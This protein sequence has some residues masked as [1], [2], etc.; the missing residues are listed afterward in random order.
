MIVKDLDLKNLY[1]SE[2]LN[3]FSPVSKA[4]EGQKHWPGSGLCL[5]SDKSGNVPMKESLQL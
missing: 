3:F 2:Q 4:V 1:L 5:T